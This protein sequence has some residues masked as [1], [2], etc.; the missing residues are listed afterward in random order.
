MKEADFSPDF[1]VTFETSSPWCQMEDK[2]SVSFLA[3]DCRKSIILN[4]F[5]HPRSL[6]PLQEIPL[7]EILSLEPAQTFSLLPDGANPH[8]FEIATASLVYYVGENLQRAESSVTGSSI[9]VNNMMLMFISCSGAT[10]LVLLRTVYVSFFMGRK[11]ITDN[12]FYWLFLLTGF[13]SAGWGRMWLGCGRW[14]SST[15]WC[16]PSLQGF[17]TAL[18]AADTVSLKPVHRLILL[19]VFVFQSASLYDYLLFILFSGFNCVFMCYLLEIKDL[20]P[21]KKLSECSYEIQ[22]ILG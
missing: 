15:L 21:F 2:N 18:T 10:L 17:P 5:L 20:I 3:D 9:L 19:V 22:L 11:L 4:L 12:L 14:P 6:F 16:Q 1:L 8:C 13:R 7:S